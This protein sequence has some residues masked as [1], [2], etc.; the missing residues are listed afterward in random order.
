[1][2]ILAVRRSQWQVH[3]GAH[4]EERF[5]WAVFLLCPSQQR[6]VLEPGP[7]RIASR[8][9]CAT[10]VLQQASPTSPNRQ[11]PLYDQYQAQYRLTVCCFHENAVCLVRPGLLVAGSSAGSKRQEGV[12]SQT[13]TAMKRWGRRCFACQG[14]SPGRHKVVTAW[15]VPHLR[16]ATDKP[17]TGPL[18]LVSSCCY[19]CLR[20]GILA[21]MQEQCPSR[22]S[23]G[24]VVGQRRIRG[25]GFP[26]PAVLPFTGCFFG[27]S[28]AHGGLWLG[29]ASWLDCMTPC[30]RLRSRICVSDRCASL[31]YRSETRDDQVRTTRLRCSPPV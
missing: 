5:P 19:C 12:I 8:T 2:G 22:L 24:Q 10:K 20:S 11:A 14:Y 9:C 29:P 13:A 31:N 26:W 3:V 7:R 17:T 21:Q 25:T 18:L 23:T 15:P 4:G 27:L 1:M 16:E 30:P 28:Y 6:I